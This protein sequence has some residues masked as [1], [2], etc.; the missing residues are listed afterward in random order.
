MTYD[1]ALSGRTG[2]AAAAG[3]TAPAA[4]PRLN[5]AARALVMWMPSLCLCEATMF[6]HAVACKIT[7]FFLE[8]QSYFIFALDL[9]LDPDLKAGKVSHLDSGFDYNLTF[10][11]GL[12]SGP[13]FVPNG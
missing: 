13:T 6:A 11:I 7:F 5:T 10:A 2:P 12:V 4:P 9:G 3:V 1:C 8:S